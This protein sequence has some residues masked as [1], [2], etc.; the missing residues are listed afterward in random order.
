MGGWIPVLLRLLGLEASPAAGE[1]PPPFQVCLTGRGA[2]VTDLTG[3]GANATDL[4]GRG[5][6]VTELTGRGGAC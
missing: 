2:N 3:R 4:D 1:T 6:D 5:A